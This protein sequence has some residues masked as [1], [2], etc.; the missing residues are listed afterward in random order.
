MTTSFYDVITVRKILRSVARSQ[1]FASNKPSTRATSVPGDCHEIS[2]VV[3]GGYPWIIPS[4]AVY[5]HYGSHHHV[6]M[7]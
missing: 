4:I 3:H 5:S 2:M 6:F 1:K 7:Q